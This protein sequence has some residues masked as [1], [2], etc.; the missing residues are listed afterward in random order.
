LLVFLDWISDHAGMIGD[1]IKAP[2]APGRHA[3]DGCG[4]E[5]DDY[6]LMVPA[7]ACQ[8]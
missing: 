8:I 3:E 1:K 2:E 7:I 6:F 4:I 5:D